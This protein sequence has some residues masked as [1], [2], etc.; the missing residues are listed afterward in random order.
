MFRVLVNIVLILVMSITAA[1][2]VSADEKVKELKA[3][4]NVQT[5]LNLREEPNTSSQIIEKLLPNEIV[6]VIGNKDEEWVKV[7]TED[8]KQGYVC[9]Q[10]L[11]YQN[12]SNNYFEMVATATITANSSSEN[13]NYNLAKACEAIDGLVLQP[14][15]EF[16]WFTRVGQASVARGYK[17]ATVIQNGKY[18]M[19]EGGGVC[20]VSTALYNCIYNLGI[21]PTEHH[22]HSLASSYVEAGMDATV[23]Y[24]SLNF[25]FVN[26]LDYTLIFEAYAEGSK[27]VITAYREK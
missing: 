26:T 1:F 2:V 3:Y 12:L 23:A 15:E 18:V 10:Y 11:V 21:E 24:P 16:D 4:V 5:R 27:V 13:R 7:S 8:G 6:T 22:H 14:G 9:S 17:K 19:G 25:K 20:Q